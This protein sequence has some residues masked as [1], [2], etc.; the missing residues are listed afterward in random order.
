M[1]ARVEKDLKVFAYGYRRAP[2]KGRHRKRKRDREEGRGERKRKIT[3]NP[4]GTVAPRTS[5]S[6][7]ELTLL[8]VK[9]RHPVPLIF[10]I[11]EVDLRIRGRNYPPQVTAAGAA[12]DE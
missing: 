4:I 9:L 8:R 7:S 6:I 1:R 2:G 11:V 12:G 3:M 10:L 5:I